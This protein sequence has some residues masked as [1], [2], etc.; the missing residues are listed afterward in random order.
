[1]YNVLKYNWS[2]LCSSIRK[3]YSKCSMLKYCL[4]LFKYYVLI[5]YIDSLVVGSI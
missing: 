1:M 5:E 4:L 3:S 2:T